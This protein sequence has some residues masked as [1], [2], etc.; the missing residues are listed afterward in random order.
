MCAVVVGIAV[1]P[2]T[3]LSILSFIKGRVGGL[4]EAI[5]GC[6]LAFVKRGL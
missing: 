4:N 6:G 1:S 2:C 5:A 3:V